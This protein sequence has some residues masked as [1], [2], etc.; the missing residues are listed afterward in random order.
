MATGVRGGR[1]V[2]EKESTD[3][4]QRLVMNGGCQQ[5]SKDVSLVAFV[6]GAGSPDTA[7]LPQIAWRGRV[8]ISVGTSLAAC[9]GRLIG[10]PIGRLFPLGH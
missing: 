9:A 3:M 10:C 1:R 2:K 6:P 7:A 5:E 8:A 4:R